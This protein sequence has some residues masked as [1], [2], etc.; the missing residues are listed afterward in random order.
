MRKTH[1]RKTCTLNYFGG[2]I[3]TKVLIKRNPDLH[4]FIQK[5]FYFQTYT[6]ANWCIEIV[7]FSILIQS[8]NCVWLVWS[9]Y[10]YFVLLIYSKQLPFLH[11][12]WQ[13]SISETK[14]QYLLLSSFKNWANISDLWYVYTNTLKFVVIIIITLKF[15]TI[16]YRLKIYMK[17]GQNHWKWFNNK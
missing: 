12:Y 5:I 8:N 17:Y 2:G 11:L 10:L 1:I 14:M 6:E 7:K 3:V 15:F 4:P 13:N 16:R 9:V